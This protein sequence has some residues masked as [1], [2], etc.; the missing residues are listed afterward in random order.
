MS[1][2][3]TINL[4]DDENNQIEETGRISRKRKSYTTAFKLEAVNFAK[5]S[6]SINAASKKF[7]VDRHTI[8]EW[9]N[10]EKKLVNMK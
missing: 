3:E 7:K 10:T 1:D 5:S 8:R 2:S 6:S 9:I 4:I